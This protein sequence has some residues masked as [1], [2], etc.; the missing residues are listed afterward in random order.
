MHVHHGYAFCFAS[1]CQL[2][3]DLEAHE[4]VLSGTVMNATLGG[5]GGAGGA[6]FCTACNTSDEAACDMSV[7]LSL[8]RHEC[9]IGVPLLSRSVFSCAVMNAHI[10][11]TFG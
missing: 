5:E 7:K 6:S 1:L 8:Y 4:L 11:P 2:N 3:E 10:R 9:Y